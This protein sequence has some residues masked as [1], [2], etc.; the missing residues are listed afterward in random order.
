ML[1]L[2]E[3]LDMSHFLPHTW[4]ALLGY[5]FFPKGGRGSSFIFYKVAAG[6]VFK[7]PGGTEKEHLFVAATVIKPTV[8]PFCNLIFKG[9]RQALLCQTNA[10]QSSSVSC[11]CDLLI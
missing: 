11:I 5:I 4:K 8:T 1:A 6:L 7:W 10:G 9:I 2:L 3:T